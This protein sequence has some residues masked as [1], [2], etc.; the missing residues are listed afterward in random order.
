[1]KT[2]IIGLPQVGKTS[3]FR[4]LTKAHL[5]EHAYSNPREAHVGIAKV[6]DDRLDR[7]AALFN[8]KKLT[9]ASVEYVDVGAIGQE[10]LKESAYLGNLRTVDAL[11]H[12]VRAFD[13]PSVPH[14]GPI[15]PLR[16]IKNVDF[17]LMVSDL[18][19]IEKRLERVEK[20]LKKMRSADLEK[21][22]DLLKR[23]KA[24]L[25]S[26]RPLREMEMT[27]EDKKR[28]R[29]FMFL[30]E[31]PMLY[32]LNITESSEL[33]NDLDQ[34]VSKNKL[35]EVA[36][37]PSAAAAAIC[38]KVE[39][40]LAEMS[41]ADAAEFLSSYGLKES[42][43]ARLIRATYTLLSLISFFTT[44]EDECRAW[45]IPVHTRAVEA[46]GAIH[47][48]LQK[49][50]IRAETIRWDQLLEAGSEANARARGTL[51]L[52]GK[53]YIVQDGDVMHIRHSG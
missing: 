51:R 24:H 5:A 32:V 18:G 53:D 19:Q 34:A 11:A 36:S 25:E 52:E 44:G 6:P 1:M 15:D 48:D 16:D 14:A 10:A 33:G 9:H 38:G 47:S 27:P 30:S 49:H 20:D 21:E 23:A 28:L 45:T 26:E 13:D 12:V 3:L 43:L 40:E 46:A 8:P 35:T 4:I 37:R 42:G 41:E 50:F 39:A 17:D 2:G 7:L 31:K 22:F 29:G